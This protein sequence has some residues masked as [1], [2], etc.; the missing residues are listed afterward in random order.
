MRTMRALLVSLAFAAAATQLAPPVSAQ[1]SSA[2]GSPLYD[3]SLPA[4]TVTVRVVAGT[5]NEAVTGADVTLVVNGTPRVART[6][7]TGRARFTDLPAGATVQ[8]KI[9][10]TESKEQASEA[11]ALRPDQG[12]KLMLSTKPFQGMGGMPPA[13]AGGP[14]AAGGPQQPPPPRQMSG[15][16][17]KDGDVPGGVYQVRLT[18]N[19]LTIQNGVATDPAPPPAGSQVTLVGYKSDEKVDV[20]VGTTD[21]TGLVKFDKL[22][23]SGHTVYFAMA[24]LPRGSGFD[25]VSSQ[26]LQPDPAV[27]AKGMLSGEKLDSGLPN[28]DDR[29]GANL[30]PNTVRVMLDGVTQ[31]VSDV[32][33]VDATTGK[34]LGTVKPTAGEPD[35]SDFQASGGFEAVPTA[36]PGALSV[37]VVGGP[38]TATSTQ[39]MAGVIIKVLA[40]DADPQNQ[41]ILD[42]APTA[43]TGPD[44]KVA[45]TL[46]TDVPSKLVM[47]VNGRDITTDPFEVAETGGVFKAAFVWDGTGKPSA[48]FTVPH[49]DGLVLYAESR[50]SAQY[51]RT[52]PFQTVPDKGAQ[53]T[54]GIGPR[55]IF[56]FELESFVED[57]MMGF[58]GIFT[59][60]NYS[61]LPYAQSSDGTMLPLP[62]GF[63]GGLVHENFQDQV[64][65]APYDGLRIVR[66]LAP[67]AFKFIAGFTLPAEGGDIDWSLD[68]PL[69]TWDS[70]IIVKTLPGMNVKVPPGVQG[71]YVQMKDGSAPQ[72]L[73]SNIRILP[74]QSMAMTITGLPSQP[75]WKIWMPR[76]AGVLVL[77]IIAGGITFALL[78]RPEPRRKDARDATRS[79]RERLLD[80]LVEL[81]RTGGDPAR[82]EQL[83]IELERIWE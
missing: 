82:R 8:A 65:I 26:P 81:E 27:G 61:W 13:M 2:I 21:A 40:V 15:T 23:V 71:R 43:T 70:S 5:P 77:L 19:S 24:R 59:L 25:R 44:G 47:T 39:G 33:L 12:A 28:V 51:Y 34:K 79:R 3:G 69:G 53:I 4:G 18:Y 72:F 58:R 10:D 55:I 14:A 31:F 36:A 68:L 49:A 30:P 1:P 80:E 37:E 48:T 6:D 29:G 38:S 20:R 52:L 9:L 76:V 83:V 74:Q 7:S 63:K 75:G 62:R 35:P 41:A 73:V 45:L 64:S 50:T 32:T 60:E 11:F 54:L 56:N 78:R 67:G 42:A 16:P 22:D 57:E 17:R 66:P 46:P